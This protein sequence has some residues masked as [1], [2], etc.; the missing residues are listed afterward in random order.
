MLLAARLV[1]AMAGV[2]IAATSTPAMALMPRTPVSAAATRPGVFLEADID[3]RVRE[4][5]MGTRETCAPA[6]RAR[7]VMHPDPTGKEPR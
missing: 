4:G 6:A 7:P 1:T 3:S 5:C 2:T